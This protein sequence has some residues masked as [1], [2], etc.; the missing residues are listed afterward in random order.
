MRSQVSYTM[1]PHI[2]NAPKPAYTIRPIGPRG[3]NIYIQYLT[4]TFI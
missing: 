4:I 1:K 2:I 3:Q